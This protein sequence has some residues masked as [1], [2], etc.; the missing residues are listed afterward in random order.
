M[1]LKARVEELSGARPEFVPRSETEEERLVNFVKRTTEHIDQQVARLE[2]K[3]DERPQIPPQPAQKY[4]FTDLQ[5]LEAELQ[6]QLKSI[7]ELR[8]RIVKQNQKIN[9][10]TETADSAEATC[11]RLADDCLSR[12]QEVMSQTEDLERL[13]MATAEEV[14]N[15]EPPESSNNDRLEDKVDRLEIKLQK[16][17][18]NQKD[19]QNTLQK[20]QI[21]EEFLRTQETHSFSN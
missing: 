6:N 7:D 2:D 3:I 12:V 10:A 19:L 8:E 5:N 21:N 14:R 20:P 17:I 11:N 4:N 13:A 18:N 9:E 16:Y 1:A 15:F